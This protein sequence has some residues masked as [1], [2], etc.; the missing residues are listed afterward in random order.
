MGEEQ[1]VLDEIPRADAG[2]RC[3]DEL[4]SEFLHGTRQKL[5]KELNQWLDDPGPRPV[6]FLS[7]GAGLGKSS[8]AHQLCTRLDNS[9]DGPRLGAS[10]FFV[11]GSGDLESTR[12]F[13]SSLAHQLAS[14]Q[15]SLCSHIIGA[16]H[17]Y[18]KG[19]SRQQM[20]HTFEGLFRRPFQ[21]TVVTLPRPIVLV[22]DGLDECKDR[23]LIPNLLELLLELPTI[24][25]GIRVFLTSRPEPYIQS[26]LT[27]ASALLSI[28][29]RSLNDTVDKWNGD[30]RLYLEQTVPR[31][32]LYGHFVRDNPDQL[33]RLIKRAAGVFIFARVAVRF[34][35]TYRDQPDHQ[36][37]FTLLLSDGGTGLSALDALYL[38]ILSSAFPPQD[39]NIPLR[40]ARLRSFLVLLTLSYDRQPPEVLA[41]FQLESPISKAHIISMTDRLRSVLLINSSGNIVP[42]HA[43]FTEFLFDRHRCV[44]SLYH[45]DPAAGNALLTSACLAA[46][47]FPIISEY[48]SADEGTPIRQYIRYSKRNWDVHLKD[49]E[50]NARLKG[51]LIHFVENDVPVYMRVVPAWWSKSAS[52]SLERWFAV[53]QLLLVSLFY[54]RKG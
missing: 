21:G 45:V 42:L 48:L 8:I 15:P 14:S 33:E 27:S 24:L 52:R 6:Y 50:F 25:P 5:F 16:A 53:S 36:E 29:H 11:R 30:V 10:F 47:T 35:D 13:F 41:L 51:D 4:K 22:I 1:K 23:E 46:F 34:L 7:G 26:V 12:L 2:Y 39:W 31:I 43:T 49:A 54:S 17:E 38:Q 40:A 20:K 3:V 37:Q 19:G 44:N 9:T 18:L 32:G 28:S